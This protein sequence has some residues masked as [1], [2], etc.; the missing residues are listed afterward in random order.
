MW[1]GGIVVDRER[2]SGVDAAWLHMDRPANTADVVAVLTFPDRIAPAALRRVLED[3]L[4]RHA[5]FRQRIVHEGP[6]ALATWE[7]DPAFSLRRHLVHR[8]LPPGG[9]RALQRFAGA[10]ATEPLD[11]ARPLWRVHLVD[12]FGAGSAVVAKV[13]HCVADGFAL[14]GVLLSLADE[15]AREAGAPHRVP[16]FRELR[17]GAP[18]GAVI[19]DALADPRRAVDLAARGAAFGR[20]L[21][22]MALL[23][24]DPPT[25]LS[26]PLSGRRRTAFSAPLPLPALRDRARALGAG[27]NDLLVAALA[28]ALRTLLQA[29]G[30]V[31]RSLR[32]LVP[33]NLR[34]HLPAA[35]G[36]L[37]NRFG[38]VFLELPVGLADPA[39]RLGAVRERMASLKRSPD[40]LVTYAVLDAI[41]HLPELGRLVTTF[42]SRK[43]SLV[44]TNV[45]GPR[46][47]LHL[48]RH[49]IDRIMF[50][51][52]H[53]AT[54]GLGVSILSYA[55][56]VRVGARADVGAVRD[57][58]ALVRGF[59][60]EL[61]ALR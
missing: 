1:L 20:S 37:G 17:L 36:P 12:G 22:H 10:V 43:A 44:V 21:A 6:L 50:N 42:F 60:R 58:G 31:P 53:P 48:A 41:G 59:A 9:T 18:A 54:L 29:T 45:P 47:R 40:A 49:E 33:V 13:H 38:L 56:E 39:A 24:A 57:P 28:G 26:R 15:A 14:V 27:V 2:L 52:P 7:D 19:R 4:L 46:A 55:G 11:A 32:A 23:P 34:D 30:E 25:A 3:K 61:E 16:S 8:R 35:G 51:V 5:R